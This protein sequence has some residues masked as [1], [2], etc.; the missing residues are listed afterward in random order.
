MNKTN[1]LTPAQIVNGWVNI[2]T[3]NP[4][5]SKMNLYDFLK[6]TLYNTDTQLDVSL[7]YHK[8]EWTK[9]LLKES[10]GPTGNDAAQANGL[11]LTRG[12]QVLREA[13]TPTPGNKGNADA[14]NAMGELYW[15]GRGVMYRNFEKAVAWWRLSNEQGNPDAAENLAEATRLQLGV[16]RRPSWEESVERMKTG[17]W[18]VPPV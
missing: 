15:Y 13:A 18:P 7:R 6:A 8:G 9:Q 5:F 10:V 11:F 12:T 4:D 1:K 14:Q 16:S 17:Y 2:D 3:A